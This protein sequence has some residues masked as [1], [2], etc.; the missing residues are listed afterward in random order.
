VTVSTLVCV[1]VKEGLLQLI[2]QDVLEDEDVENREAVDPL[3]GDPD[4]I[5]DGPA[6]SVAAIDPVGCAD[7]V[8]SE[9]EGVDASDDEDVDDSE[10]ED[11][12]VSE[13]ELVTSQ[14]EDAR[15]IIEV[16]ELLPF[17]VV[18]SLSDAVATAELGLN[19]ENSVCKKVSVLVVELPN[20]VE[21]DVSVPI[22]TR[23]E[24]VPC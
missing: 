9:D 16:T 17:I 8:A 1:I 20:E 18:I 2:G 14:V 11:V 15:S 7:I 22:G 23:Q 12:V 24:T 5:A 10:D 19:V 21:S 6:D 4:P 3:P 13:D